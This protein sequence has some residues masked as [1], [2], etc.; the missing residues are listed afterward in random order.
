MADPAFRAHYI[1]DQ[2]KA[3]TTRRELQRFRRA[4][5]KMLLRLKQKSPVL[6][7]ATRTSIRIVKAL[8][9]P[10]LAH[11]TEWYVDFTADTLQATFTNEGTGLWGPSN[12]FIKPKTAKVLHW[13]DKFGGNVFAKDVAGQNQHIGWFSQTVKEWADILERS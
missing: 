10:T 3:L 1:S 13:V 5:K 11:H 7:G 12:D 8:D 4:Q 6:T 9:D 2:N